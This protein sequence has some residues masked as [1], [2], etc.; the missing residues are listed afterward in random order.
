MKRRLILHL[1]LSKTGTTTIQTFLRRNPAALRA[2]GV[3]YPKVGVDNPDHPWFRPA[4]LR[5]DVGEEIN[6]E[7]L[8]LEIAQKGAAGSE[9]VFDTPLWSTAFRQIEESGAH[10]A[11]ISYENFF[12]RAS[13]YR[14]DVLEPQ[15]RDFDITGLIYLRRQEDWAV[16]LYGQMIRGRLRFEKSF[17][18]FIARS[19]MRL[20]YSDV[21]DVIREHM[22]LDRLT[23]ANFEDAASAGLIADFL[24]RTGLAAGLLASA[25]DQ[26]AKNGSLPHWADLFL[27]RCN[28]IALRDD[29]FLDAR[30]ALGIGGAR[31]SRPALRPGLDLA[32]PEERERLRETA[33]GDAERLM[34]RYGVATSA[35]TRQAIA[36]RSFDDDD[37][38][39]IRGAIAPLVSHSTRD[40]LKL[41]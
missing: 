3:F 21:L 39:T 29:A 31:N 33:A 28:Q 20:A 9:A 8:A 40:A 37:F 11:V 22:P 4:L 34:R 23:V 7:A 24:D 30:R 1:G 32:T 18:D 2:A 17:A 25:G 19:Q 36:Y 10:T 41:A 27:L 38:A 15:L 13:R 12:S 14:F 5:P 16:S 35:A 26:G 6:H